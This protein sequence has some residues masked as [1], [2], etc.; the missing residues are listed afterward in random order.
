MGK[1]KTKIKKNK[2][3]V[4]RENPVKSQPVEPG[5]PGPPGPPGHPL[6]ISMEE[7]EAL[8]KR[9]EDKKLED[10]DFEKIKAFIRSFIFIRRLLE[11]QKLSIKK[12]KNLFW[13]NTKTEKSENILREASADGADKEKEGDED[14]GEEGGGSGSSGSS[15]NSIENPKRRDVEKKKKGHGKNG[16]SAYRGAE[17]VYVPHDKLKAGHLC[18]ECEAAKIYKSRDGIEV[19]IKGSPPLKATVYK[20][21]K[22]R[23]ALCG[24]VYSAELPEEAGEAKYDTEAKAIISLLKYGSGFPYHRLDKFQEALGVPV[25]ASTQWDIV[26]SVF[27]TAIHPYTELVRR[28]AQGELFHTDDTGV[29]ILSVIK[30]NKEREALNEEAPETEA[31]QDAADFDR[32]K[33]K[34][35]YTSGIMSKVG[36]H[37]ITLYFSGKKYAGENLDDVLRNR[38]MALGPPLQMCDALNQNYPKEFSTVII[39]CLAHGRRKFVELIESYPG[40]CRFVIE[41]LA[42]VYQYDEVARQEKMSSWERLC[43]HQVHS[44]PLMDELEKWFEEQFVQKNVEPNSTLGQVIKYMQNHWQKLTGFLRIEG[45]PLDNNCLERALKVAILNRKNAYFYKTLNGAHVGD[46]LMSLIETCRRAKA[47][48]FEYLKRIQENAMDVINKPEKWLPWNYKK[49][50]IDARVSI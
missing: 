48:P 33:R 44:K 41:T 27:N 1:K 28:A 21:E 29:R 5:P 30:E 8:L 36:D 3:R 17:V 50:S 12:L 32:E 46:V 13:G 16:V 34:A 10:K 22:F 18:P 42:E 4:N 19:R 23:C 2:N 31:R 24:K 47:D 20:L 49:N 9:I 45:A 38:A 37:V 39:N 7:T 14:E 35:T 26:Y 15:G 40:E 25:P 11:R 6:E 43:F